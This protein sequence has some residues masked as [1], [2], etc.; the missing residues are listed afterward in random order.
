MGNIKVLSTRY[1]KEENKAILHKNHFFVSEHNFI[2]IS[3]IENLKNIISDINPES[4]FVFT[5]Q[6]AFIALTKS[7]IALEEL[8]NRRRIYAI[9]GATK[10][11]IDK[12][13]FEVSHSAINSEKLANIITENKEKS[14]IYFTTE[15]RT[16]TL[17]SN[18][19]NAQTDVEIKLVYKKENN[20]KQEN[21]CDA[22][23]LFSPSQLKSF[24][25]NNNIKKDVPIFCIGNTT[26][27][28]AT[29]IGLK[30]VHAAAIPTESSL[31]DVLINYYNK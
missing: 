30:N 16:G 28:Y 26:A 24:L 25:V 5:S 12:G 13:G 7:R 18:L 29:S 4:A 11:I 27:K 19:D 31:I 2:N 23:I 9:S 21:E 1:L 8:F 20:I 10:N 3:Y 6:H 15:V 22:L 14:L 17:E